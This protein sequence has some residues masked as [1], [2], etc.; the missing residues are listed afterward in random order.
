MAGK[1]KTSLVLLWISAAPF[2]GIG[3]EKLKCGREWGI[4]YA[5]SPQSRPL[6]DSIKE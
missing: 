3:G 1:L 6:A 2:I 4:D 5:Q